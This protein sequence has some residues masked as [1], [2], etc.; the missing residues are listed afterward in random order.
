M[1]SALTSARL[2]GGPDLLVALAYAALGWG[3]LQ[4]AIAPDYVSL[5]FLP[6]GLAVAAVRLRGARALAGV[7]LGSLL[8]QGLAHAQVA[9]PGWRWT[10]LVPATGAVL[11]AA[12]TAWAMQRWLDDPDTL[13]TPSAVW[14]CMLLVVPLG[15]LINPGLSVPLLAAGGVIPADDL[16]F[17]LWTWWIGDAL[18]V[19]LLLPVMLA[20]FG[21]PAAVWRPRL[22]SVA[23]PVGLSLVVM[24]GAVALVRSHQEASTAARFEHE[25]EEA[26][27][28]LQRRLDAL[29]DAVG[30]ISH[31]MALGERIDAQAFQAITASWLARYPGILNFGWS[32]LV[33]GE[34]REA[35]ERRQALQRGEPFVL[36]GRD[37]QGRT[38]PAQPADRH[39][40]ITLVEPLARNRAVLGLDVL[41]LPATAATAQQAIASGRPS[42]S[43]PL[44]LVQETGQQ[45]GVVMYQPVHAR[46][47]QRLLGIVSAAIRVGDLLRATLEA[48]QA[49]DSG[50]Q[51]CLWDPRAAPGRRDLAGPRS[52]APADPAQAAPP[53]AAAA[54]AR[55]GLERRASLHFGERRWA[56]H[57]TPSPR[58]L[59]Q[60]RDWTAW[61][62]TATGLASVGMLGGFLLV[63]TGQ[64]R[65]SQ[66]LVELRT[67]ELAQSNASLLQLAHF[68]PLTGLYNRAQWTRLAQQCLDDARRHGDTLAVL[69]IDLDRFKHVNDSLG[70]SQGDLLLATLAT[71]MQHCL[72]GRDVVARLGGDE[73]VVLLPRLRDRH[74]ARRAAEKLMHE[75]ARPVALAGHEV[76]VTASLG[77]ACWPGDGDDIE[78]LLQ[79]A[80]IAMYAAKDDGRNA[81]RF[82]SRDL[83]E[84]LSE[85]LL[86]ERELR[87]ALSQDDGELRLV[88]Q[89]QAQLQ[90]GRV[91]GVEA[92][93]RWQ[94]PTRGAIGPDRFIPVAEQCGLIQAVDD[95]VL[96]QACDRL[97]RWHDEQRAPLRLAVN[98]SAQ[99]LGRDDFLPRLAQALERAGPAA[100]LLELEI[101]ESL[102]MQDQGDLRERLQALTR[103]G[104]TLAL[105]DFGTGYSNLGYLKRLPLDKLKIDRSFI[106]DLPGAPEGEALVRAIVSMAHD[107]GLQ[108]L[109]EG[110]ETEAQRAFLQRHGCD[111]MQGW[112]LARALPPDELQAWLAAR[113]QA[114]RDHAAPCTHTAAAAS[115]EAG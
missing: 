47:R 41:V 34:A 60:S 79:H 110:V 45:R 52:C 51:L 66:R 57:I 100:G 38:F 107:L 56:L 76:N 2:P 6:A 90:C 59:S 81:T 40:P 69:F 109:A 87:R 39:L 67:H 108:V 29:T 86:L 13:D 62:V 58:F 55:A 65:R 106:V 85:H 50:L 43:D 71:R 15:S 10:M 14:R 82:F 92:L 102:L 9:A 35:F 97:R 46:D 53:Q 83:Q 105:D 20:L 80:D 21:R 68:D 94:H 91:V 8:V 26:I 63:V 5:V 23:L 24:V 95:W 54:G 44:H 49:G 17:S 78:T 103:L 89:P 98:L 84:R 11:Q 70:H 12:A 114:D 37:A 112:L 73:F 48:G 74:G 25:S 77:A 22:R 64:Q 72:R 16:L 1:T 30:A 113:G 4:I 32:P 99:S 3:S 18:G 61:A 88:Y 7:F 19:A 115:S 27:E 93:L 96:R 104:P 101:T 31:V 33:P 28:R 75:L 111:L 42:V 36:R